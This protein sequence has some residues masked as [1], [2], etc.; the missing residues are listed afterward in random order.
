MQNRYDSREESRLPAVLLV[1][2][3]EP[4]RLVTRSG[5]FPARLISRASRLATRTSRLACRTGVGLS[6]RYPKRVRMAGLLVWLPEPLTG[7]QQRFCT[8]QSGTPSE[9][10]L[11]LEPESGLRAGAGHLRGRGRAQLELRIRRGSSHYPCLNA[12]RA[13][14]LVSEPELREPGDRVW[15]RITAGY[16]GT[17]TSGGAR[18]IAGWDPKRPSGRAVTNQPFRALIPPFLRAQPGRL[19]RRRIH[20][21]GAPLHGQNDTRSWTESAYEGRFEGIWRGEGGGYCKVQN[22]SEKRKL[23]RTGLEQPRVPP[24]QAVSRPLTN[25]KI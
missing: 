7:S 9:S 18:S 8:G 17:E 22:V 24:T 6:F 23:A 10:P 12:P 14:L 13:Q 21:H 11:V 4:A 15:R 16:T 1:R 19:R 3:P 5:G 2:L 20:R 25:F